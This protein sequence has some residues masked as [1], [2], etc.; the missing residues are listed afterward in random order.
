MNCGN[1]DICLSNSRLSLEIAYPGEKYKGSR[2]DWNGFIT[3]VTLDG[4][5]TFCVPESLTPGAGSGGQGFCGEFGIENA[6]GYEEAH[7]GHCFTKIG[8]GQLR[9]PDNQPYDFFRNYEV[10]PS[11]GSVTAAAHKVLFCTNSARVDGY[12]CKYEKE[13]VLAGDAF[14]ISYSLTNTGSKKIDTTEYCH[15]FVGINQRPVSGAYKLKIPGRMTLEKTKGDIL[16]SEG[17]VSWPEQ[18]ERQEFYCTFKDYDTQGDYSWEL[19]NREAGVGVRET[20][21]F[22]VFKFALWGSRHVISPETFIKLEVEPDAT[23]T[24]K[25]SYEFFYK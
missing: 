14:H 2:F 13:I 25:R 24:W 22:P 10:L 23:V 12:S 4:V 7:V 3:Q 21:D 9:K 16:E 17:E 19:Y 15:N 1:T 20:D 8:V 11:S 5:H 6:L 18:Q